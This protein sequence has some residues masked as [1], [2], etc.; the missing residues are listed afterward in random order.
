MVGEKSTL[1]SVLL[2]NDHSMPCAT[3]GG[4]KYWR[5]TIMEGVYN[6]RQREEEGELIFVEYRLGLKLAMI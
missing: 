1:R 5:Q 4:V 2:P 3:T 6:S